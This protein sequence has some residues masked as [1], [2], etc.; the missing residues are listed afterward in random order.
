MR[1]PLKRTAL[2]TILLGAAAAAACSDSTR[3]LGSAGQAVSLSF[4][5]ARPPGMAAVMSSMSAVADT[6]KIGSGA[7]TLR[8]TSVE[9]VLRKIELERIETAVNC[10]SIPDSSKSCEEFTV[11]AM[12]VNLPVIAGTSTSFSVPIDSGTYSKVEFKVHKPGS[13][14]VDLAFIAAN[15]GF[16]TNTSIRVRGT[17]NGTAFTYTSALDAKQEYTFTPPLHINGSGSETNL[18]I[19]LDISTWFK[20]GAGAIVNPNT[21]NAGGA[22][23][24]LVQNNIKASIKAF[25]DKDKNGDER[26]G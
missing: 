21:A 9:I 5:G 18:T 14:A 3:P 10:D 17:F 2:T 20:T 25:E 15:P 11:G 7:D 4:S 22:N 1:F 23:E 13:D 26:D 16:P 12:L 24:S 8:I 19:R 6:L